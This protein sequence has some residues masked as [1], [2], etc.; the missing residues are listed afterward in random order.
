MN[1]S[2]HNF[3]FTVLR[4]T[5]TLN[6]KDGVGELAFLS[7]EKRRGMDVVAINDLYCAVVPE[8]VF[9]DYF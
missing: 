7:I 4:R 1:Y 5:Q 9:L 3:K 6:E 8:N 2:K